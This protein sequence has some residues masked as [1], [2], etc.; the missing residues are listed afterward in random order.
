VTSG[1]IGGDVAFTGSR[2]SLDCIEPKL[3]A[4]PRGV[5][6]THEETEPE[7][8]LSIRRQLH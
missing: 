1:H 5:R 2:S 3:A 6:R 8:P 7:S 4:I